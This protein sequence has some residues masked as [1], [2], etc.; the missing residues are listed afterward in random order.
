MS[1]KDW[2][3]SIPKIILNY[4]GN[5]CLEVLW[6]R[7][8]EASVELISHYQ[9][10]LNRVSYK[11]KIRADASSVQIKGLCG[12]RSYD[13]SLMVF[14]KSHSYIPQQSNILVFSRSFKG[15]LKI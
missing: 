11:N 8:T 12:G 2:W 14:P 10:F 3:R 15:I 4:L 7:P 9:L 1:N 6:E 5:G 13:I